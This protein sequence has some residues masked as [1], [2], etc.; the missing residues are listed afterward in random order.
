MPFWY[1][2]ELEFYTLGNDVETLDFFIFLI[3]GII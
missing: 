2:K 1:S 3:N